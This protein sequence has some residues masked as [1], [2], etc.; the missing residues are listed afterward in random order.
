MCEQ[1]LEASICNMWWFP[2]VTC[3]RNMWWFPWVAICTQLVGKY[4]GESTI[5]K[6]RKHQCLSCD[7]LDLWYANH[8]TGNYLPWVETAYLV[9]RCKQNK[10]ISLVINY[11]EHLCHDILS[12]R[13]TISLRHVFSLRQVI[14]LRHEIF[15]RHV[16]SLGHTISLRHMISLRH[17]ISHRHTKSTSLSRNGNKHSI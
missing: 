12:I 11:T 7:Y 8:H 6:Q 17:V 2:C 16:I 10:L 5:Y 13:H 14:S 3:V 1:C 4:M 15:L 9:K